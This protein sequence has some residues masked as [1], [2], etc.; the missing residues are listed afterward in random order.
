[1]MLYV[2]FVEILPEASSRPRPAL[3]RR[4]RRL[5]R[6]CRVLRRHPGHGGRSTYLVPSADNPHE[7]RAGHGPRRPQDRHGEPRR[8]ASGAERTS[9]GWGSSRPTAIAIHNFPE[10][11]PPSWPRSTTRG[12]ASRSPPRWRCT[13]FPKASAS[14]CRSSTRR[15]AAAARSRTRC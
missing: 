14:R 12:P 7:L 3:W 5:A 1:M 4:R 6:E 11:W 9:G 10:G 15:A 13:T 2:S 8:R